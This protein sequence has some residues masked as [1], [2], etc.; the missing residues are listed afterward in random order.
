ME[1]IFMDLDG[2]LTNP[3][4]GITKSVQYALA[5]NHIHEP[6]LDKL[7]CYIGPPLRASFKEYH[8]LDDEEAGLAV[9]KYR[10]YFTDSGIFENEVY[11]G[12]ERLLARLGKAGKKLIVATSKPEYFA[13]KILEHFAL[14]GYF[15]DICGAALDESRTAKEEVIR[16]AMD[17]NGIQDLTSVV[18]VGDRLHDV[19]GAKAAGIASIGVLYGFGSREELENAGADRIADTVEALYDTIMSLDE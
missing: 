7:C 4:L 10:E 5:A 6:D 19:V 16:Y 15:T 2:T 3:R 18:M 14:A 12:M 13:R 11:D 8:G 9:S 17:K 1:Y